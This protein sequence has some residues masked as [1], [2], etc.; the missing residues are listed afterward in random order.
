MKL[1]KL[2]LPPE[3]CYYAF[4][5][6]EPE[7]IPNLWKILRQD[8]EI[9]VSN[10]DV[11]AGLLN[12]L[13]NIEMREVRRSAFDVLLE[14]HEVFGNALMQG[15]ENMEDLVDNTDVSDRVEEVRNI[16]IPFLP[17]KMRPFIVD[18][19]VTKTTVPSRSP[20]ASGLQNRKKHRP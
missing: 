3:F 15:Y 6:K 17:K 11:P 7:Q 19:H 18:H 12:L 2:I 9:F 16:L 14:M 10:Y 20:R 5:D 13:R 4:N 1:P 8:R